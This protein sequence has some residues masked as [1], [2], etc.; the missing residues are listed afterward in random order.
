MTISKTI[1]N[2]LLFLF[3]RLLQPCFASAQQ[4][5]KIYGSVALLTL[6]CKRG[7]SIPKEIK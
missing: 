3:L 7:S 6:F 2:I 1:N 4:F 5:V